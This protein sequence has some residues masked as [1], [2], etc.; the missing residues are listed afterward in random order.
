MS[1]PLAREILSKS[2][3]FF[4][5][6]ES[7]LVAAR[8]KRGFISCCRIAITAMIAHLRPDLSMPQIADVMGYGDHTAVIYAKK[9]VN[10]TGRAQKAFVAL[11]AH[12]EAVPVAKAVQEVMI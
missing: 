4:D 8:D 11:K 10:Q 12:F 3:K 5:L 2:A 1:R 9:R 7:E 6:K